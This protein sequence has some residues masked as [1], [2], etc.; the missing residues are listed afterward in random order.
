MGR[1]NEIA[2]VRDLENA[3]AGQPGY[4]TGREIYA[5]VLQQVKQEDPEII[6]Y[7]NDYE[8]LSFG[9]ETGP[10]YERFKGFIQEAIDAG[11]EVEGIGFQA[12]MGTNLVAPDTP[13][14]ILEDCYQEFGLPIKI[15][16][17][18]LRGS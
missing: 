3:L 8:I 14:A 1:D 5:E 18:D 12:H 17:Y 10:A 16:E 2:H 11:G 6:S 4:P 13:Y 15:T 7:L 9:S